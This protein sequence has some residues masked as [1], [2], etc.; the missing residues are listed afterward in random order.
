MKIKFCGA[1]QNVTGSRH[2]LEINGIKILLDC[3]MFQG[4]NRDK[5]RKLNEEF[6]FDPKEVDYVLISHAH[7][8]H[9]G[10]LPRLVKMGFNGKVISTTA[11]RDLMEV[12]L[13]DSAHI[14]VQDA[15]YVK[16]HFKGKSEFLR[17]P[18]YTDKDVKKAMELFVGYNYFK[19]F[20][21]HENIWVTLY[22][23]GH[24]LGS[25]IIGIDFKDGK[26]QRRLVF[27]GDLGRKYMPILNDPY[28]V[29]HADI[30]ITE[31]TYASHLHDSIDS[32]YEEVTWAVNDVIKRGGKIIVPSFSFE[33]TQAFVYVLHQLYD[34]GKIPKIPIFVDSPLSTR[35]SKVFDKYRDYYDNETFRDFLDKK[36]SPFY[37][38]E[39]KYTKSVEES[40]KLNFYKKP[41][42]IISASGMCEAGRIMHHLKNHMTDPKNMILVIGFMAQGT[43]GRMI[44]EGKPRIKIYGEKYPLKADV[45]VLNSFSSHADKLE[46]LE[47]IKNI[48]DLK[49]IF[50]VHGE[51]SECAMLRDNIYNIL[52]LKCRVDVADMGEEF[53]ITNKGTTSKMGKRREKYKKDMGNLKSKV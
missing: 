34:Q 36:K 24:V 7:I 14:Q 44:V 37:F 11:N 27:T 28:Q 45:V 5:I 15:K 19:K 38:N 51:E 46:L 3:G 50:I 12:M 33:R 47:Y 18:L 16:K 32:V 31:S 21:L 10:M 25:A 4:G 42:I 48:S 23:A 49:N 20:K 22:D 6:L 13:L 1:D 39:I 41:C 52:K 30:L 29:D 2:L 8:D 9:C 17:E 40:K 43:R 53:E 26:E 35:I